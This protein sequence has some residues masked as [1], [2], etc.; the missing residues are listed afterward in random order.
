MTETHVSLPISADQPTVAGAVLKSKIWKDDDCVVCGRI[1]C[2]DMKNHPLPTFA[3]DRWDLSPVVHRP[4]ALS[5]ERFIDFT[6]YNDPVRQIT[7]KELM[8]WRLQQKG[9]GRR[10][11]ST[12]AVSQ[13]HQD[14]KSLF[15]FMDKWKIPT[16]RSLTQANLEVWLRELR[17]RKLDR[18]NI[19]DKLRVA[20]WLYEARESLTYDSISFSCWKGKSLR[21]IVGVKAHGENKTPR[22]HEDVIAPLFQWAMTYIDRFAE[23]IISADAEWRT[24]RANYIPKGPMRGGGD[25]KSTEEVTG[26]LIRYI[27]QLRE[28]GLPLPGENNRINYFGIQKETGISQSALRRRMDLLSAAAMELGVGVA[29]ISVKPSIIPELGEAWRDSFDTFQT[30]SL[31]VRNL[32]AACYIVCAYLS[33]MRDCE[34]QCMRRGCYQ[35]EKDEAGIVVRHK[36]VSKAFKENNRVNGELGCE[37]T[38][39]VLEEVARAVSI[40]ERL[41]APV[42]EKGPDYLFRKPR[43]VR[44]LTTCKSWAVLTA[45]VNRYIKQFIQTICDDLEPRFGANLGI[46]AMPMPHGRIPKITVR[47]FRRTVAW[48]IANQPFGIV[49]GMIQYGHTS[50]VMFEGYAGTSESGF[51]AEVEAERALARKTDMVELYEDW[52]RGIKPSGPM[53]DSLESE[54]KNIREQLGD[55]TGVIATDPRRRE[56]MLEH[57]RIRLYPGLLADCFFS[58]AD[59]KCLS[60][61]QPKERIEPVVGICDP[62]C[63]NACWLK[64]HLKVWEC[65]RDDVKRLSKRNRISPIQRDILKD[66]VAKCERIIT[67]ISEASRVRQT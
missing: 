13:S 10:Y 12:S 62:N 22:I 26:N 16:L 63:N 6:K 29:T 61:L 11:L 20:R 41:M 38:W 2:K 49:A 53:A 23:D 46:P 42:H 34:V 27:A 9:R 65:N 7:A 8:A 37:R 15:A 33:G 60:H 31:E 24:N 18:K 55:F 19:S 47:M 40:M 51:R 17:S 45:G 54:F 4:N 57:L 66:A 25:R 56:K 52:K 36:I 50:E 43:R 32:I 28:R 14:I 64:K 21:Q 39:I 67:S 30:F 59:A 35:P 44:T 58:P 48:F 5:H 3:Q 1:V